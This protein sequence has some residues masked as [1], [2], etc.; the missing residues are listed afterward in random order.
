[1]ARS[2][3]Q[4]HKLKALVSPNCGHDGLNEAGF[5]PSGFVQDVGEMG[6]WARSRLV[7]GR[8]P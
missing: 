5:V 3:I 1:V 7:S 4:P 6:R 2:S 8:Y